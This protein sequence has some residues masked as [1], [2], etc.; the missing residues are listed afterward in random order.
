METGLE[1]TC[2]TSSMNWSSLSSKFR[3][4]AMPR[5]LLTAFLGRERTELEAMAVK[6]LELEGM[7]KAKSLTDPNS[8]YFEKPAQLALSMLMD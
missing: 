5:I 7:N 8:P 3:L 1:G 2:I 6:R 4:L